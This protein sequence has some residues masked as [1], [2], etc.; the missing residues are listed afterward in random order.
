MMTLDHPRST[1]T[2]AVARYAVRLRR[3]LTADV[4]TEHPLIPLRVERD[5]LQLDTVQLPPGL[6]ARVLKAHPVRVF[7]GTDGL[8]AVAGVAR[9]SAR[10]VSATDGAALVAAQGV[11]VRLRLA[12][13]ALDL[14][15]YHASPAPALAVQGRGPDPHTPEFR[16]GRL[17]LPRLRRWAAAGGVL[18]PQ[19]VSG[20]AGG[21]VLRLQPT[22]GAEYHAPCVGVL[23][24]GP[25]ERQRVRV[26]L[27]LGFDPLD[28]ARAFGV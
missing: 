27:P 23:R 10:D 19:P 1:S 22:P 26:A 25:V 20:V 13:G 9:D 15:T 28:L 17:E 2:P 21:V 4:F 5:G 3:A 24:W 16:V 6:L 18:Y 7:R 12:G 8:H 14:D 11:D